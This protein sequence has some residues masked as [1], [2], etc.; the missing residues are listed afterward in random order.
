M[1]KQY[2]ILIIFSLVI[3]M[4]SCKEEFDYNQM[5]DGLQRLVVEGYITD[6]DSVHTIRIMKSSDF[7]NPQSAIP[8]QG[9]IVNVSDGTNLYSFSEIEPG[10]YKND[11]LFIGEV[12]NTYN[13][14]I[15]YENETY[16]AK[17]SI[18]PC[19]EIDIAAVIWEDSVNYVLLSGQE[20]EENNQFYILKTSIN[21]VINDTLEN[22]SYFSDEL[23][24]GIY[25]NFELVAMFKGRE[26]DTLDISLYSVSKEFFEY[27][28]SIVNNTG[29]EP[30]PFFST[31]PANFKGNISNGGLG[32]FQA[33]SVQ[34]QNCVR[35]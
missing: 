29:Y 7:I 19:F 4:N 17:S 24:N 14:N 26:S 8:A 31:T 1:K 13:L 20:N 11:Q 22:W 30:D 32:F 12:G 6:I 2:Y 15:I 16:T 3:L 25:F 34:K 35:M 27:F 5:T 9:A 18:S 28:T 10:T 23:I 33:S 21:G